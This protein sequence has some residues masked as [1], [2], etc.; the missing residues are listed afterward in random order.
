MPAF[1]RTNVT[2]AIRKKKHT[3]ANC[4]NFCDGLSSSNNRQYSATASVNTVEGWD[5]KS[6]V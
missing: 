6:D 1:A 5:R 4:E 2:D 3:A